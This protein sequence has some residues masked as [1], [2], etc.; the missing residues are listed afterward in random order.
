[1]TGIELLLWSRLRG[2]Q[3]GGHKFRRQAALGPFVVDFACY[4]SRLVV[5]IDGPAHYATVRQDA[6]R[7]TYLEGSGFRVLR[8]SADHILQGLDDVLATILRECTSEH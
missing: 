7:D 1:M 5:E 3:L 2:H 6:A 8:F 4:A